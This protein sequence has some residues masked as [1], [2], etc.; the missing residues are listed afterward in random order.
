MAVTLTTNYTELFTQET[1]DNIQEW[2][3]EGTFELTDALEFID[4]HGEDNFNAYYE[5][6]I[7][8]GEKVGYDVVDAFIELEGFCDVDS[9]EDAYVGTYADGADFAYEYL[10]EA[11]NIPD[12]LVI[13]WEETW[14]RN[15]SYDYNLVE[16]GYRNCYVFRSYY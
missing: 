10:S 5:D 6:Y 9:C 3:I 15:L 2:C 11:E 13:D 14:Q 7:D 8:Q 1:V 16:K 12:F 4:E